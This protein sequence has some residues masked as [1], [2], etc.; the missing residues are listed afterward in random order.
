M[1]VGKET[2]L[3]LLDSL[4]ILNL[5]EK[6]IQCIFS[7]EIGRDVAQKVQIAV[8]SYQIM[9][10]ELQY[11]DDNLPDLL[12]EIKAIQALVDKRHRNCNKGIIG[13]C[14]TS[15]AGGAFILGGIL[16]APFTFGASIGLSAV[17]AA[18]TIGGTYATT[19]AKISDKYCGSVDSKKS[20]KKVEEFLEHQKVAKESYER[21][22]KECEEIAEIWFQYKK[23]VPS[24]DPDEE[25]SQLKKIKELVIGAITGTA[26][27][28]DIPVNVAWSTKTIILKTLTVSMAIA[29][30]EQVHA[31]SKLALH[32]EKVIEFV[33]PCA[34]LAGR[35]I[36]CTKNADLAGA[37][38]G[39]LA[40]GK[41]LGVTFS[42]VGGVLT[43][44][45]MIVDGYSI[46]T[47]AKRLAKDKK[48]KSSRKIS[49]DIEQ[50]E[51]LQSDLQKLKQDL[52]GS[53]SFKH[54]LH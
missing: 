10:Q 36:K 18:L 44:I 16:A 38:V 31:A 19:A 26:N 12:S 7:T 15:I 40:S 49:D 42:A 48:C 50:L 25:K 46:Y 45:G 37:R 14:T 32:P 23:V 11:I 53:S 41:V 34:K 21:T 1:A 28:V 27:A 51:K 6:D 5:D 22:M 30:P 33:T 52:C 47:A 4:D 29:V 35:I 43:I 24:V 9:L 13:G 8:S 3:A 39:L 54:K 20:R 2:P 17:G